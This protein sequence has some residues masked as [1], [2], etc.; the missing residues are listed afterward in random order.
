MSKLDNSSH[1]SLSSSGSFSVTP[2]QLSRSVSGESP[3]SSSVS[4]AGQEGDNIINKRNTR[5]TSKSMFSASSSSSMDGKKRKGSPTTDTF[6]SNSPAQKTH[7]HQNSS[8]GGD[9]TTSDVSSNN[10]SPN[11]KDSSLE[12]STTT[13]SSSKGHKKSSSSQ[14]QTKRVKTNR[15]CDSCRRKKIRCDVLDEAFPITGNLHNGNGGLICAHCKQYGFECTFYLPITET[16]FKKKREREAEELAAAAAAA[17]ANNSTRMGVSIGMS[18]LPGTS[19]MIPS[20]S[21]SSFMGG[22]STS[23]LGPS[24]LTQQISPRY[25]SAPLPSNLDAHP[26]RISASQEW[27]R[28]QYEE[29]EDDRNNKQGGVGPSIAGNDEAMM[30]SPKSSRAIVPMTK[31]VINKSVNDDNPPPADTRVLGPTSIAYIVHSTAF[32]PG[33]AIEQHDLK[34]HQTFEVGASGDGIIKFHKPPKGHAAM[35]DG[36]DMGD[37]YDIARIPELIRGRLAGD[38]AEK[39]VNTYFEKIGHLFP[40][41]TKSEFLHLSPPPPLLL[42]SICGIATLSRDVPKE[43][44]MAVKTTL[45]S[46]FRDMDLLSNSNNNTVKALLIMSLHSDLHGNTAVQ[47]GTR[48]W[49]RVGSA[50]RMAQ[51]LGLHRDASGRDDLDDDA[52]F[53]EQKRRIWG[54]CVTADRTMSIS[55]GHPLAIDLTDCDV[56]LPS[57]HE[58]LRYPTDL[59]SDSSTDRPFAFNTEMLK[60]SIL[61]GRVMK[62]I[63]SPTG[64]MKTSDEDMI[65]L[66]GDIDRW[67][68][69]LPAAL[70]FHGPTDSS[71]PAGIL[72]V[73]FAC[74]MHLLFRVFMRIS[75]NCPT[76]LSFSLTIERMTKLIKYSRE[77]IEWVDL[78]DFYLDTL[79]FVSYGLVFCT[80]IQY[81]AWIRRGDP[82]ALSTLKRAR[83][84]VTRFKR[85]G[86]HGPSEELSMRA[87]TAEVIT[88]LHDSALGTYAHGP[89]T[90]NLNPTAGVTNRRTADTLR[91]IVFKQDTSRPGGGVYVANN[92]HLVLKDLP[93]GTII[94]QETEGGRFPAL[95]RTDQDVNGG[96]Q[97]IVGPGGASAAASATAIKENV[98]SMDSQDGEIRP[99]PDGSPAAPNL[100]YIG[101][102][103]WTDLEGRP[104][105]RRGS[106]LLT[107][108]PIQANA[109]YNP[110]DQPYNANA[111]PRLSFSEICGVK[112]NNNDNHGSSSNAETTSGGGGIGLNDAAWLNAM[113]TSLNSGA[114]PNMVTLNDN[115]YTMDGQ[116]FI[117]PG[118]VFSGAPTLGQQQDGSG[119]NVSMGSSASSLFSTVPTNANDGNNPNHYQVMDTLSL[120]E[121]PGGPLDFAAW[122][123]WFRTTGSYNTADTIN[124]ITNT[125]Q[126]SMM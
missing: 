2:Y 70:Q 112:G 19:R 45:N 125:G 17:K 27:P 15:A 42:Y 100:T 120:D 114:F 75:Y 52:F 46:L 81:H 61:F 60:L 58:I 40:V 43:V 28:R 59:P 92:P 63:Y 1:S 82:L 6:S 105:N 123:S 35:S 90:G 7:K 108:I 47:G 24:V 118:H 101:G 55:L 76:H 93:T 10:N 115:G 88:M 78:N 99:P 97:P 104:V 34:H 116:Q 22:S 41:M 29:E 102:N 111:M 95:V 39:L 73:S 72:H 14:Q 49:N 80:T 87:K 25:P 91:G 32:V 36:E 68:E 53:L 66:L 67:K 119:N 77:A 37:G 98:A 3:A 8:F 56:R 83:E 48:C 117:I 54:C 11:T 9:A 51:D 23:S 69:N 84:C 38:V 86:E 85:Q 4:I 106:R 94:L 122:D 113:T 103:V 65:G 31:K 89:N 124:A 18:G 62:T 13:S 74:L 57:P 50:I 126:Q 110:G 20:T 30:M 33:A 71:A 64:L 107:M 121:M 26:S 12:V 21:S 109:N 79:Q 16:R 44:L 96:W 5:E